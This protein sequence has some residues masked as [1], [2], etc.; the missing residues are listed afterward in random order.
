M[1]DDQQSAR[2]FCARCFDWDKVARALF[3]KSW[4]VWC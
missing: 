1:Y 4:L 3:T 2:E